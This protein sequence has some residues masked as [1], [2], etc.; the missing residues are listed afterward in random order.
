MKI[1][2]NNQVKKAK[3]KS[4]TKKF[5]KIVFSILTIYFIGVVC[6][7]TYAIIKSDSNDIQGGGNFINKLANKVTPKPPDRTLAL[8]ACTDKDSFRTDGI[9]LVD[10]NT[11]NNQITVLSIP[12]DTKVT[13]IPDDMWEVMVQNYPIIAGDNRKNKKINSIPRYGNEQGIEFLKRY[14]EDWLEIE[15]DYT[16]IFDLEGFRYI[17]DSV[18]GIEFDV[19]MRMNYY[20]PDQDFRIDLQPGPQLLDGAKAE[21]LLRFRQ[22]SDGTGYARGDLQRIEVQQEFM[23]KF[24]EKVTSLDS[25]ISNPKAYFTA[26]TKYV[27]TNFT[28]TDAVKYVG[29]LK[30]IDVTNTKT[31]TLP[32]I[33]QKRLSTGDV[34]IMGD[35]EVKNLAYE[36]FEA[37]TINPEDIVYVDSFDK[38]IQI[39]NGSYTKGMAGNARDILQ[40][41]GYIVGS[42]GDSLDAKSKETK[43]YVSEIGQGNDLQQFF[44]NS[45]IIVNPQKTKDFGYDI[46]IVIGT[47]DTLKNISTQQS[48]ESSSTNK[49]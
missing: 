24:F 25:I 19:P 35:E 11:I 32:H 8:V 18:G 47:D 4:L 16:A 33:D 1:R 5:F 45:K 6:F 12:R 38:S 9:M 28:I 3:N 2:K 44:T 42:I 49:N 26:L 36:L 7:F 15:I 46:T 40:N 22:N 31:Y 13:D 39:L 43:I 29:E 21:Q 27:D 48:N 30:E 20:A 10:Y 23:K 37:P 14:L 41:N 17:I 34:L